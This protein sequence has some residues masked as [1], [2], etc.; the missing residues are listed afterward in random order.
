[1]QIALLFIFGFESLHPIALPIG[2]SNADDPDVELYFK[3]VACKLREKS[4]PKTCKRGLHLSEKNGGLINLPVKVKCG[5]GFEVL[6]CT[7]ACTKK[8]QRKPEWVAYQYG[9]WSL[10]AICFNDLPFE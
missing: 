6:H 2:Q 10:C 5:E 7:W 8:Q 1:M 4:L 9:D 3:V